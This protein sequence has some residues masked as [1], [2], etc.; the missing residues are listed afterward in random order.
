VGRLVPTLGLNL[1]PASE[2]LRGTQWDSM[3]MPHAFECWDLTSPLVPPR[4][5]LLPLEPIGIGT[6]FVES[7]T[8]YVSRLAE[9]HAVRVSDLVGYV[10]AKYA[11]C[12][13][14]I[15]S[16]RT[17]DCRMGSGFHPGAHS[18]NGVSDDAR[19]WIVAVETATNRT[20]LRFLTLSPLKQVFCR[21]SLFR[22]IQAWCPACFEDWRQ[23]GSLLYLPLLWALRMVSVCVKHRR[24]LSDM[25]LTAVG[26]SDRLMLGAGPAIARVVGAGLVK[27]QRRRNRTSSR[28][29]VPAT[30]YGWQVVLVMYWLR[31]RSS[32]KINLVTSCAR[33]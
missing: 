10:L 6:P 2:D 23:S 32:R 33:T 28:Y 24:P 18:I 12:D 31:C 5:L 4:T 30:T 25:S 20:S 26:I 8:S 22:K 3:V 11:P 17:R 27:V 15:V 16:A 29:G 1:D 21:Q 14:P 7:L 13:G 9:V 19:R